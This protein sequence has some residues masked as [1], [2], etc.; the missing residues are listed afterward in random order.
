L[1][2]IK[3]DP[4]FA[5][6]KW[7]LLAKKELHTPSILSKK[8]IIMENELES[9]GR[10]VKGQKVAPKDE[11]EEFF[12]TSDESGGSSVE[13]KKRAF[14]FDDEDYEEHNK[15]HNRVRSYSFSIGMPR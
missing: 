1:V 10:I 5:D 6:I 13:K 15:R 2:Q 4:F 12:E 8:E 14:V 3:K 7:D 11:I 9:G